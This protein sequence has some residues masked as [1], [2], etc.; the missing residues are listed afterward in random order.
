[1]FVGH[2]FGVGGMCNTC[3][4]HYYFFML[5]MLGMY[6]ADAANPHRTLFCRA[7]GGGGGN[8]PRFWVG[9]CPGRTKKVDP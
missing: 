7:R 8:L 9:M 1:M 4:V 6:L 5:L 2:V 3:K